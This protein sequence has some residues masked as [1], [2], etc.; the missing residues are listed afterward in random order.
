MEPKESDFR[1]AEDSLGSIQVPKDALWGAT[2]QRNKE[3]FRIGPDDLTSQLMPL[4]IIRAFGVHKQAAAMANQALGVLDKVRAAAICRAAAEVASGQLDDHFPLCVWQTGS[5]TATHINVNEVIARRASQDLKGAGADV[6]DVYPSDHVNKGQSTN[7]SM[8]TVLHMVV[9]Q[10]FYQALLPA[11]ENLLAH[12]RDKAERFKNIEKVGRTHLQ[13]AVNMTLGQEWGT[14]GALV[15]GHIDRLKMLS[16]ALLLLPQGGTAVGTG[17]NAHPDF[18]VRFAQ[19]L[20]KL[21]GYAF[22]PHPNPG[23]LISAHDDVVAFGTALSGLAVTLS[24][25]FGDIRLSASGPRCGFQELLLP[26]NEPGSSIMPGKVNPS[27]I[28]ALLMICVHVQGLAHG[29]MLAGGGGQFQLNVMKPLLAHH[30]LSMMGLLSSA[31]QSVCVHCLEGIRANPKQLA[32]DTKKNVM[33]V[34]ALT[35]FVGYELAAKI[36]KVAYKKDIDIESAAQEVGPKAVSGFKAWRAS[37]K[38]KS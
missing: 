7:D 20:S 28:E 33:M 15:A 13:D 23:A 18:G 35:P 9:L 25:I 5:G 24:K 22:R 10:A 36:A 8:G 19:A 3:N 30:L 17:L 37:Q 34:T 21:T 2:T 29:V 16:K 12:F 31:I 32:V 4:Q 38:G 27:Q 6:T 1:I 11:L 26:E 14:F